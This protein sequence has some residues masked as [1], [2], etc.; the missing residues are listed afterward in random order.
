MEA[1]AHREALE[2]ATL[3]LDPKITPGSLLALAR[4]GSGVVPAALRPS[5]RVPHPMISLFRGLS[6]TADNS[7][8][9]VAGVPW[10]R[11]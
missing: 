6:Q 8:M 5:P 10:A 4:G 2:K 7:W 11:E 9:A 1:E 3:A